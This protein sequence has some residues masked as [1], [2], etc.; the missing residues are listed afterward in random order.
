MKASTQQKKTTVSRQHVRG[1]N[2]FLDWVGLGIHQ[3]MSNFLEV[4]KIWAHRD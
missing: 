2:L 4:G 1:G 3:L